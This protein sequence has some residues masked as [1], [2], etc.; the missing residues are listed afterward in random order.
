MKSHKMFVQW[1]SFLEETLIGC[2]TWLFPR[3]GSP[4]IKMWGSPLT[5]IRFWKKKMLFLLFKFIVLTHTHIHTLSL[6]HTHTHQ[7]T[8]YITKT[9]HTHKHKITTE[10]ILLPKPLPPLT[11]KEDLFLFCSLFHGLTS[12]SQISLK[13]RN[14]T[15]SSN[16]NTITKKPNST[17]KIMLFWT[18]KWKWKDIKIII[19]LLYICPK[20]IWLKITLSLANLWSL[21]NKPR[22]NPA[23]TIWKTNVH[24]MCAN[25]HPEKWKGAD[26]QANVL[27]QHVYYSEGLLAVLRQI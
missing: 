24:V 10:T 17:Q 1:P 19:F 27:Q 2:L 26:M 22:I 21:P 18:S 25:Q 23:F 8:C 14:Q 15:N 9:K 7:S 4:T 5:G 3:P 12:Y 11:A 20:I 13:Y 6:T 16:T